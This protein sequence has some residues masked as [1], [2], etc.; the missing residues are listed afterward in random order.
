MWLD[1]KHREWKHEV[2]P[3][4]TSLFCGLFKLYLQHIRQSGSGGHSCDQQPWHVIVNVMFNS[5]L[6][7]CS[8]TTRMDV[9]N[10]SLSVNSTEGHIHNTYVTRNIW[11]M[12]IRC[13]C[14]SVRAEG[15]AL[16]V[17]AMFTRRPPGY[18]YVRG[19]W[20]RVAVRPGLGS[21]P[22]A[23]LFLVGLDT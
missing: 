9:L 21:C 10:I 15:E 1:Q 3:D 20:F 23:I 4:R 2:K 13:V 11:N 17:A 7:T 22:M 16:V 8:P 18:L 12:Y 19:R 14:G 5:H 6:E